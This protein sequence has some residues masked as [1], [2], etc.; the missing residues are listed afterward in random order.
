VKG[1]GFMERT[2]TGKRWRR[3]KFGEGWGVVMV[4]DSK[5]QRPNSK[6]EV[7]GGQEEEGDE[8]K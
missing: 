7:E 8:E 3:D 2:E 4:M 5:V 1:E 6:K